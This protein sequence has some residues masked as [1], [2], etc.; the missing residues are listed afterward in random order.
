[1]DGMSIESLRSN[2]DTFRIRW[3][4]V[5]YVAGAA[6]SPSDSQLQQDGGQFKHNLGWSRIQQDWANTDYYAY[7][8][9]QWT[10]V[11][12]EAVNINVFTTP[13]ID[14][15]NHSNL[16]EEAIDMVETD[17]ADSIYICTTPDYN[18]YV[19]NTTSFETDFIYPHEAV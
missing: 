16:V 1:M 9:G 7:L 11:N 8:W 2:R 6:P 15:A 3:V 14:Y 18:M 19:P 12:P 10:F 13:G 5:I 17:R 4:M